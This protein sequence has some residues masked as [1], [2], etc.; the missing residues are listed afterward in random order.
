MNGPLASIGP[1]FGEQDIHL[2]RYGSHAR[3]YRLMGCHPRADGARFAVWAPNAQAVSVI[4]EFNGWRYDANP[5]AARADGTGI[6]EAEVAGVQPGQAYKFAILTRAGHWLE[7]ADPFARRAEKPPATGSIVHAPDA[8]AWNDDGWMRSRAT[9]SAQD[10]PMSVYEVHLGSWRRSPDGS[11]LGYRDIAPQLA[12]YAVRMGFTHVELLP[13]TE[14]PF[15]GSWGYQT[16]AYFAPTARYGTPED[17][18]YLVDTLHQA[19]LGVV[20]D[21]VPSHFPTDAHGLANF[22]GA[23]LYEYADPRLGFHPEWNSLI[24]DYG[25]NEVRAFLLSSALFWLDEYHID[26]L[27]ID[28]VASMLYLDYARKAGEWLPN[29]YGGHE[30]LEAISFLRMLNE[31]VYREHPDAQTTAEESTA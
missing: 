28:A 27:R 24:F 14:H 9:H 16:T 19:G 22:D 31:T 17:F 3:L 7:K 6:W 25:R 1:G 26:V 15:Y 20:L 12:A 10:A 21:W 23:P 4:G 29:R 13:V 8:Y 11:W 2:F 30:N 5:A 18:K